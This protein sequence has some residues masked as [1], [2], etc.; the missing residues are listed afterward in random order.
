MSPP[1]RADGVLSPVQPEP[2]QAG[3]SSVSSRGPSRRRRRGAASQGPLLP[4]RP[5][6]SAGHAN[7]GLHMALAQCYPLLKGRLRREARWPTCSSSSGWRTTRPSST[8]ISMI[9][10]AAAGSVLAADACSTRSATSTRSPSSSSTTAPPMRTSSPNPSSCRRPSSGPPATWS[11]R[12]SSCWRSCSSPR[13]DAGGRRLSLLDRQLEE[14]LGRLVTDLVDGPLVQ[15]HQAH[16]QYDAGHHEVVVALAPELGVDDEPVAPFGALDD[17][18][19]RHL[20]RHLV[21][22]DRQA[23][24]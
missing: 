20:R 6:H 3:G 2:L 24:H 22:A 5:G 9:W 19:R 8:C 15:T 21:P 12:R 7:G 10:S 18:A 11:R 23:H 4:R 13:P 17:D 1:L 16:R 14:V